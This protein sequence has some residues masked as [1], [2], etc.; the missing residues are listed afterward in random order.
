M[1]KAKP[2]AGK[3]DLGHDLGERLQPFVYPRASDFTTL[4]QIRD[5]KR[6]IEESVQHKTTGGSVDPQAPGYHVKLGSG[7]I[8][9]IEFFVGAFQRLYG[10]ADP[11][12]C[13]RNTLV[14]LT[15]L[16]EKGKVSHD[17][18][19][20]LSL[21]YRFLRQV[22]NRLQMLDERQTHV[23]PK[24]AEELRALASDMIVEEDD[25]V[26][27]LDRFQEELL[28]QTSAVRALFEGI[29]DQR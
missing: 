25:P 28:V 12:L 27:A 29:L 13:E 3:I 22:E 18:G 6:R 16:V 4:E 19:Q 26:V 10:G 9:D 8:R 21:A 14:A 5:L 15:R 11:D 20:K 2:I 1:V 17:D 24:D 7:G 23:L